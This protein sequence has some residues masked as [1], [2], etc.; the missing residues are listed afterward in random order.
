MPGIV[1][2]YRIRLA[3]DGTIVGGIAANGAALDAQGA[4]FLA[5]DA[6]EA[7]RVLFLP[8]LPLGERV[9]VAPG[10]VDPA[11]GL[12]ACYA[13]RRMVY[14]PVFNERYLG[15]LIRALA[16]DTRIRRLE[17]F[18]SALGCEV[19]L[20]G[21]INSDY[22]IELKDRF[23]AVAE[24]MTDYL[25]QGSPCAPVVRSGLSVVMSGNLLNLFAD[26]KTIVK[27]GFVS[28]AGSVLESPAEGSRFL[29]CGYSTSRFA[30]AGAAKN[31]LDFAT[32]ELSLETARPRDSES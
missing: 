2:D 7:P 23:G 29:L 11:D 30:E 25:S 19:A 21:K 24:S 12:L 10:A 6:G 16:A 17:W 4:F 5:A 22:F 3:P 15:A 26:R 28:Y 8:N 1:S 31:F 14:E 9:L 32:Q 18:A 13:L 27:H 20:L